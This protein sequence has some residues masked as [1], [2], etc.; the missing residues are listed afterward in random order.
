MSI[1]A[2]V[3]AWDQECTATEKLVLLALADHSDDN[4]VC[5]PGMEGVAQKTGLTRRTVVTTIRSME[6]KGLLTVE[7]RTAGGMKI[8]NR[9]FL[10]LRCEAV[11]HRCEN[12]CIPD[13]KMTTSR[14]EAVSH[15][16]SI[17]QTSKK[18]PSTHSLVRQGRTCP[19][20]NTIWEAY[21]RK[22]GKGAAERAWKNIRDQE[23]ALVA[24]R[25]ALS[26]Q[27][28]S[29]QWTM[30]NGR[31]IPN[32]A[33]YLNQRRWEDEQPATEDRYAIIFGTA[34]QKRNFPEF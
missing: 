26:W 11:S 5:W 2:M 23:A 33:T 13:V 19:R 15:K 27:T 28:K 30:E 12:D 6:G 1:R 20:F 22:I 4:G 14:C 29:E 24:I 16:T 3:W 17:R 8:S 34:K 7:S 21:P 18:E 9:Y 10:N 31:Y 25:D 32:P